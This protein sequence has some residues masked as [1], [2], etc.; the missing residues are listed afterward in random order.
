MIWSLSFDPLLPIWALSA[1]AVLAVALAVLSAVMRLPAWPLRGLAM[2]L[3]VAALAGPAVERED[4]EPLASVV[5][6][7]VDDSQSQRL[8]DR[9]ETTEAALA[10]LQERFAALPGYEVRVTR[11][12]RG[13]GRTADGTALF[14]ALADSLSDVPPERIGGAVL[15]TDGQV[16]DIPEKAEDL[17]FDAPLHGLVTGREDEVDRRLAIAR[18]PKFAL[19]G[20]QQVVTLQLQDHGRTE[21][22]GDARI[23]VRRD[24]EIVSEHRAR[25]GATLDIPVEIAHG[26]DNIFEF[27][28]DTLPG[29]L[30]ELNNRVVVTVEG[31]REN[32]RVLLVSGSP[33]AGER[34]W[35]NLLKSDASVDL[36]HFT[37]LRPPNKQ[38]GTPINELSLIAF[39]TRELFST[40]IDEFD[41]IIFDRYVR[42]GVLPLLYFDNIAR[43]VRDGGAVLV[44]SGPDYADGGSLYR[45]PLSPVLPAEPTGMI[46]EEPFRAAISDTGERH[47]VTRGLP[48]ATATPP[49]WSRWFR[50]VEANVAAG[51]TLM[52]GVDDKPLL[53]LSREGE[54]RVAVLL[55]DHV[56]LWARGYEGGGPHVPLLRRLAHWLMQEPDLEEEALRLSA[57][58]AEV[59]AERQ[60]I[61]EAVGDLTLTLPGGETRTLTPTEVSPGLWRANTPAPD[62][63]LYTVDD[64]TR[65]A[66]V[67]VGPPNPREFTDVLS[68]TATLAGLASETGGSVRRVADA[69]GE[70]LMPR[71]V[72][73]R[74]ASAFAGD[75]WIGFRTT[76]ASVL[77]GVD[78]Y[79]LFQ[80]LLG[81]ALLLGAVSLLWYREGR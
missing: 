17:G 21:A 34:T 20:S 63:G 59:V 1:A 78:R 46:Y 80:G 43:Y 32:L 71:V 45:T 16:H 40:K 36:V 28:A 58:G 42:R 23:L 41:L 62:L 24:G 31:I 73:L 9:A 50:L 11:A 72:P 64:G 54:G 68:T 47:P 55:S 37:I 35:R 8:G 74:R 49:D 6:V 67:H 2:A 3:L 77:K 19:V 44:A 61:S 22:G 48:G 15:I 10:T 69:G 52:N 57:R 60:T 79:P 75:G 30:T 13:D 5:S 4:R 33:H 29:E 51:D 7:I 56:W 18:A 65:K 76:D 26:G 81:L 66:L 53:V 27:S 14:S 25:P 39:P 38:D 12:G 70:L